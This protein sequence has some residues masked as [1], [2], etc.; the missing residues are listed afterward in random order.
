M[1]EEKHGI[2]MASASKD[3]I[4][5]L[6]LLNNVL[7]NLGKY[8]A[9]CMAD[10]DH[11]EEDEKEHLKRIFDTDGEI[12]CDEL[13]SYLYGL[14]WG[15]HRVVMGFQVL[16][17]NCCDPTLDHLDW[18]PELKKQLDLIEAIGEKLRAGE[19]VT[20]TPES[21]EGKMILEVTKEEEEVENG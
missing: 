19:S 21:E 9:T 2:K 17:D 5:R 1:A 6:Y 7:E 11:F 3:D 14:T 4:K 12:D 20:I 18:K 13:I 8:N 10:F 16:F 15:F